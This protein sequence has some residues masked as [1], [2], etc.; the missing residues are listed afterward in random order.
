M[1]RR[2]TISQL[3]GH[4]DSHCNVPPWHEGATG[5]E[6]RLQDGVP[7]TIEGLRIAGVN[8]WVLTGDKQVLFLCGVLKGRR[9]VTFLYCII[10]PRQETAIS[11]GHSSKLLSVDMDIMVLN[12][13]SQVR[14]SV[15]FM[16]SV[17]A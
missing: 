9:N 6:D 11:V 7:E 3:L 14:F 16:I 17:L 1:G 15:L 5:I 2:A 10:L 4:H 13:T 8:V 12:A